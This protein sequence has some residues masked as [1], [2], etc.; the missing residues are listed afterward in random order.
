MARSTRSSS[1]SGDSARRP[2]PAQV[3]VMAKHPSPGAVKTR[4]A[5]QIGQEAACRLYRAFIRDLADRLSGAG[6]PVCWAVWPSATPFSALVPGQRCID[7]VG[8][9]LGERLAHA[10]AA[11][12]ATA[13]LPVV[14]IGVDS[15]HLDLACVAAAAAALGGAADVVLGPAA[16]G[17]YYL[18]ALRAPCPALFRDVAWGSASV[19]DDTLARARAA[20]LR[21]QLLE[22]TF[23][24][25]DADGLAALRALLATGAVELPHT[26]AVL[27]GLPAA[28]GYS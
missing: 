12:L 21:V 19:L 22:P 3:L 17:G 4:L 26:A 7:Q 9:D 11:C 8:A 5:A 13:P 2:A 27:A 14:A 20:A 15:P 16:D 23:D 25:D 10:T 6:L 28:A 1:I 18:I 24:V